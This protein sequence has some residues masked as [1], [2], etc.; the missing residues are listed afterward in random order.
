MSLKSNF[1]M[2]Y[3]VELLEELL[4]IPSPSGFCHRIME[5]IGQEAKRLG[6]PF[7]TTPKGGGIITVEGQV[8]AP[9][10]GIS[11]HVDT[12]GAMVRSIKSSGML[13]L[14][15]VG[16]YMLQSIEGEYCR[17]HTRDGRVYEGTILSTKP[18]VHVYPDARELKREESTIEVRI[19]ERVTSKEEVEALGIR[20]GDYVSFE[21]RTKIL[22]S[23]YIKSRHLDDKASVAI[24]FGVLH[25]LRTHGLKP[26]QSIKIIISNYE[27]VGHGASYIPPGIK[28]FLAIDMGALGEDLNATE[29]VVSICAKDSSGPYDYGMTSRLIA[30]AEQHGCDYAVDI[31]PHYGSDA[32]AALKA[33]HNIRAA[34]IGPGVHASH[35]MERTHKD[36]LLNTAVLIT[37]YMTEA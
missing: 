28:E 15:S 1:D 30:L 11:A 29:H 10:L 36:A 37:A 14:T 4:A 27:E 23:G 16:G 31:Y 35:F 21:P 2:D 9:L 17:I 22:D 3:V 19:D 13:R 26:R 18:S 20:P 25:H 7:E 33:G 32:S 6:Y 34:L 8:S 5:R 24:L 12:L